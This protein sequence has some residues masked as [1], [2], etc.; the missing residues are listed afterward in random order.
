MSILWTIMIGFVAGVMAKFITPGDN[1]RPDLFSRQ[2]SE[3]WELFG[4]VF[5]PS[6]SWYRA[7][8]GAGLTGAVVEAII[9]LVIWGFVAGRRRRSVLHFSR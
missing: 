9:I 3:L 4:H 5:R 8:E 6:D 1:E 2:F 7:G